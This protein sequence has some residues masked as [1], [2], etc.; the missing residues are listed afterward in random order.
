MTE[1]HSISKIALLTDGVHPLV[2]G[3]MQKHSYHLLCQL[4]QRNIHVVLYHPKSKGDLIAHLPE[5]ASQFLTE[6]RP[7]LDSSKGLP[8]SY[9]KKSFAY[10]LC[11]ANDVQMQEGIDFIYAQG[12]TGWAL[13][14]LKRKGVSLP[15][16][17]VNFHGL[18]M[19]QRAKGLKQKLIQQMFRSPV[20]F[21]LKHADKVY[22]LGGGLTR[23]LEKIVPQDRI[24]EIPIA[25][26]EGWLID[27]EKIFPE[28][29][30][31]VLFIGRYERRKGIEELNTHIESSQLNEVEYHFVGPIPSTKKLRK[32]NVNY[33]GKVLDT[34]QLRAIIDDC[35]V[36]VVPSYSEGMPTVILE[37]MSRGLIIVAT[38]VGAVS[39]QV[40]QSNGRLI[41]PGSDQEI[42]RGIVEIQACSLS[43][44]KKMSDRSVDKVREQFTWPR[45]LNLMLRD[46]VA[47]IE[48]N[49]KE[50]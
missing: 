50:C 38:N 42:E 21:N 25:L 46:M 48:K 28:N 30:L 9:L 16:M 47:T 32:E 41:A 40:D 2:L 6:V 19:F 37:A 31:K 23:I 34:T 36:L 5:Q 43:E 10:A 14:D 29:I 8:G 7:V 13:A 24:A 17:G 33:H 3:G 12:F 4:L 39:A 1:T 35:Q 45:V 44:K 22:A 18:E 15:P 20:K 49:S 27:S 26:D 11:I